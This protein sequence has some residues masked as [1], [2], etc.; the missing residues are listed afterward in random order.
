MN[1]RNKIF[2]RDD[3]FLHELNFFQNYLYKTSS[4]IVKVNYRKRFIVNAAII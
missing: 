1:E 4:K 3:N 2:E